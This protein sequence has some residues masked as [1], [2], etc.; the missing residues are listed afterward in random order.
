MV[1]ASL[2]D[3]LDLKIE[4]NIFIQ[5]HTFIGETSSMESSLESTCHP[6]VFI[7]C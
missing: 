6:V 5:L 1:K 3:L 4:E 2:E 7:L